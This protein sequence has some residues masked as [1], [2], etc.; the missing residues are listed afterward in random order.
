MKAL[1]LPG[2]LRGE[3]PAPPSKSEAHR[4]LMAA[5]LA[6]GPVELEN[7]GDCED[8]AA[9]LAGLRALGC[10]TEGDGTRLILTPGPPPERAEINCGESGSTFRFLLP[11]AASLGA[12]TAF[13]GR[14]RLPERPFEPLKAALE[15]HGVRFEQRPGCIC[16]I[17]GRL[18]PGRY[19]LPGD[20]SSQFVTGLLFAL[21]RLP[22]E[23][24]IRLTSPLKSAGYVDMTLEVLAR[25]GVR[26]RAEEEGWS[27]PGGQRAEAARFRVEGDWSGAAFFLAAGALGGPVTVRGL[28]ADSRQGDRRKMC[29]R[30]RAQTMGTEYTVDELNGMSIPQ[31]CRV[32]SLCR[33][34]TADL[35]GQALEDAYYQM[36][37]Y[38]F[39]L[40]EYEETAKVI[41][42]ADSA[43]QSFK[44]AYDKLLAAYQDLIEAVEQARFDNLIDSE[45]AYQK[46]LAE[47]AA[48]KNELIEDRA[49]AAQ[50]TDEATR[51]MAEAALKAK[52]TAV[53]LAEAALS[54]A[55][56]LANSA[57]DVAVAALEKGQQAL[58]DFRETLPEEIKTEL[59]EKAQ[60][61]ED[62]ANQAKDNF[63]AEFEAAHADDIAAA[64]AALQARKDALKQAIAEG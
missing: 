42:A 63:F 61:I 32:I 29:I 34:E 8:V 58:V 45:S 1:L 56:D 28:R 15:A 7:L 30:D 55:G 35:F 12:E 50:I 9:T 16:A 47:L 10:R 36:K 52:E 22:G 38:K 18:R 64:K 41:D 20:I 51:L 46:A 17:S 60:E 49:A 31:L 25:F 33:L 27:V 48:K 37:N 3:L 5:S 6:A 4:A 53:E 14:G 11:A 24:A 13:F 59:N 26:V 23:S 57:I 44:E 19:E 21:P 39:A 43:Y 54:T 2:L 40:T 62:K